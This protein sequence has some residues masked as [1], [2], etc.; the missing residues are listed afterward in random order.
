[1]KLNISRSLV[2]LAITVTLGLTAAFG[3]QKFIYEDLKVTG[4][5]YTEIVDNKDLLADIL[6][7]PL[8]VVESYMLANE[9]M[10]HPTIAEQ[11]A[12]RDRRI[13]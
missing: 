3:L 11:N 1:M 5:V 9:A 7:P 12:A 13:V 6:P 2:L 10:V 8:Y 4:P